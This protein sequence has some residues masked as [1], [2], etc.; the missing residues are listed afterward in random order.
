MSINIGPR[1]PHTNAP[2]SDGSHRARRQVAAIG[3]VKEE[4]EN[5]Y[6]VI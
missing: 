4:T 1:H 5:P 2:E 6:K 3:W